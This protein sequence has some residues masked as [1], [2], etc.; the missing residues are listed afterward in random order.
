[1]E[2]TE[3]KVQLSGTLH[4]VLVVCE[5]EDKCYNCVE[6]AGSIPRL[7]GTSEAQALPCFAASFF[8]WQT[9]LEVHQ[10]CPLVRSWTTKQRKKPLCLLILFLS[11]ISTV[12]H[13]FG[14]NYCESGIIIVFVWNCAGLVCI[15]V[16]H[17]SATKMW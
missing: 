7:T 6:K 12:A 4:L 2:N 9:S 10:Y 1:M 14:K 5:A 13:K 11:Q 8:G 17:N 3:E 16:S 15:T